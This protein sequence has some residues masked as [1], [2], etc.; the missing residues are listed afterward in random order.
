MDGLE[1]RRE[2]TEEWVNL[3]SIEIIQTIEIIQ[4]K[5]EKLKRTKASGT[6][7]TML[8]SK[9]CGIQIPGEEKRVG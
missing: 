7:G 8:E 4:K 3:R 9:V 5:R 2:I 6:C 1:R